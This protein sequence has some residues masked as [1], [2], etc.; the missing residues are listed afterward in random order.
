MDVDLHQ[1]EEEKERG[2]R[3]EGREGEEGGEEERKRKNYSL[4]SE[5]I[6]YQA[7]VRSCY[8]TSRTISKNKALL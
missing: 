2:G 3:G 5:H 6:T 4:S 8:Y 7:N 1:R